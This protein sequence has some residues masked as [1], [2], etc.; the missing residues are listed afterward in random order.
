ML[1][2]TPGSETFKE[3]F[4]K[5]DNENY[6]KETI[7]TEGGVLDHGFQKYMVRIE[8]MG[9]EEKTSI[10]RSTMEYEVD[11]EHANTPPVFSTD[12]LATIAK[13]ITKYIKE[14]KGSV[15]APK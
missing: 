12:G 11:D 9:K 1:L 15:E 13:A 5:V 8:I 7:V 2:G 10:I 4:I 14:Q 3:K 6:I